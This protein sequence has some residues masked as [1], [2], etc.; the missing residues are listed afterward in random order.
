MALISS[1]LL[2]FL[3]IAFMLVSQANAQSNVSHF[4]LYDRGNY[5]TRS[6]YEANLDQ[7]L[8]DLVFSTNETNIKDGFYPYSYGQEISDRVYAIGLCRGDIKEDLCRICLNDSRIA[9]KQLCPNQKEAIVWYDNCMLRYS[10]RLLL[11]IMENQPAFSQWNNSTQNVSNVDGYSKVIKNLLDGM[12][13]EAASG[14]SYKCATRTVVAPDSSNTTIYAHAQCTPDLVDTDCSACLKNISGQIPQCCLGKEGGRY[15]TPSCNFRY[16]T[17]AFFD[18]TADASSPEGKQRSTTRTVIIIIVSTVIITMMIVTSICIILKVRR[19]K[20]KVETYDI[21]S[22]SSYEAGDEIASVE[23]LQIDFSTIRDATDNFSDAFK[24]GKGGFGTVYKGKL[25]NGREIAVKRLSKMSR[26]GDL[27]FKNEVMLVAKL[28]HR[29]LVRLLGFCLEGDE[30]LLIYEFVPN[31]SL[32]RYIFDPMKRAHLDWERRYKIIKGIARG[33]LYLHEDSRLRIIHRD[34]KAGNILLD[35]EMNPKVSDFGMARMFVLD[36]TE[37]NTNRIVGTYGYM[38]P[39]YAMFGQFSVKS[40][41]F[42]FGVLILEILTGQKITRFHN[43]ENNEYL[44]SYAWKV[45]REGTASSIIDPML[46]DSPITETMRCINI[47]LLCVQENVVERPDMTAVV[48]MLSGNCNTLPVP[49]QP[50]NF[51]LSNDISTTLIQHY[52]SSSG[53]KYEVSITELYPR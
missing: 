31:R 7:T 20:D 48:F 52:N 15:Y 13:S 12:I 41:V 49:T 22:S 34:L 44:L 8:S 47:G 24:L 19:P 45:W 18:L 33:L 16:G 50:A 10:N 28:Q 2:F 36:Q 51:M 17:N 46:K 43:E 25:S 11:C 29:N 42:S 26:Q 32:D 5:S 6:P 3:S 39:E 9:L 4:C 35:A 1:P 23:S 38:A 30:R 37:G 14:N 21:S 27:Q 53:A 40:D